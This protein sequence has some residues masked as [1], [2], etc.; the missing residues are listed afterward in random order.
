MAGPID[1]KLPGAGFYRRNVVFG[2]M[3]WWSIEDL[4]A[5]IRRVHRISCVALLADWQGIHVEQ[6]SEVR[7][8]EWKARTD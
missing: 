1:T 5:E 8:L 6:Q 2:N 7:L 3:N 4:R